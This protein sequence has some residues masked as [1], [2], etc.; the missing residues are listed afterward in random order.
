[1]K[2]LWTC[3]L[4]GA[5]RLVPVTGG[6][7]VST[8]RDV[9]GLDLDGGERWRFATQRLPGNL[10]TLGDHVV[11]SLYARNTPAIVVAVDG[12]GKEAWRFDRRWGLAAAGLSADAGEILLCGHDFT[13]AATASCVVLDGSTGRMVAEFAAPSRSSPWFAG[14]W[15][16]AQIGDGERGLVRTDRRGNGS[17]VVTATSH[18]PVA[19]TAELAIIDTYGYESPSSLIALTLATGE[20]FWRARGGSNIRLEIDDGRVV[21]VE[22]DGGAHRPAVRALA[23]GESIWRGDP[24]P[25]PSSDD[26]A[27]TCHVGPAGLVCYSRTHVSFFSFAGAAPVLQRELR[28]DSARGSRFVGSTYYEVTYLGVTAWE[29]A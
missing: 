29:L 21:Y 4:E 22:A 10:T 1:M 14:P 11:C 3:A 19:T 5:D 2:Q 15:C 9:I 6:V 18:V 17:T 8:H 25:P 7:A 16:V 26:D 20:E 23:T 27:Y 12:G 28:R 24:V 13:A